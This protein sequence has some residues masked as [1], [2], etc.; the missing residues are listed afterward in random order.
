MPVCQ[1]DLV[2]FA[3]TYI[4]VIYIVPLRSIFEYFYKL[5]YLSFQSAQYLLYAKL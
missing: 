4:I 1:S 5:P 2:V 3:W